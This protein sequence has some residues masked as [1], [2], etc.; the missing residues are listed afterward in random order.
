[1]INQGTGRG[2]DKAEWQALQR[3][4][5][6]C[7][8]CRSDPGLVPRLP[9][10]SRPWNPSRSGRLLLIS[11]APPGSGGFWH[12]PDARADEPDDLR[13][14]L[15]QLLT[16]QGLVLEAGPHDVTAEFARAYARTRRI[17]LHETR[18]AAQVAL[19]AWAR[20]LE[21]LGCPVPPWAP[22]V[23][24]PTLPPLLEEYARYRRQHRGVAASSLRNEVRGLVRFLAWLHTRRRP[25]ARITLTDIDRF[26]AVLRPALSHKTV[27]AACST[28]RAFLRFLHVSG[29][30]P[31]DLAASVAA[32][33]VRAG[34]RPPRALPW[35]DV[36]RILRSIDRRARGG[37]RDYALLLLMAAYGL[38]SAEA[39]RLGLDDIDWR[40]GTVRIVRPKTGVPTVLPLAWPP[41]RDLRLLHSRVS[42]R[43]GSSALPTARFRPIDFT[44]ASSLRRNR[45]TAMGA[46][47]QAGGV[48][49]GERATPGARPPPRVRQGSGTAV[50]EL[51]DFAA[52]RPSRFEA[53]SLRHKSRQARRV[54]RYADPA[55]VGGARRLVC[56]RVLVRLV[57]VGAP[58]CAPRSYRL[59]S[60]LLESTYSCLAAGWRPGAAARLP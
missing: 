45:A 39:R 16:S 40:A 18:Y 28:L 1:M 38:G 2:H 32:P 10:R 9:A 52:R 24:G 42:R 5:D 22:P 56:P 13:A 48:R 55:G 6:T 23:P 11:E 14:Q 30:L 12:L 4:I 44:P 36:R 58:S 20:G 33:V 26:V 25:L 21:M 3:V 17:S 7:P 35:A 27:A 47:P 60:Q 41:S 49:W 34:E 15:L 31:V 53:R 37:R 59:G 46:I 54:A 51:R 50:R 19:R 29:R 43:N 57:S 8:A